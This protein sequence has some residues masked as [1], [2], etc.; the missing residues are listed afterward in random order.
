VPNGRPG[1]R[2][3]V[4]RCWQ[5]IGQLGKKCAALFKVNLRFGFHQIARSSAH[6]MA[7][8]WE[9]RFFRPLTSVQHLPERNPLRI[10]ALVR[11]S[12]NRL[13]RKALRSSSPCRSSSHVS[14]R[15]AGQTTSDAI[16]KPRVV[17]TSA[18]L[19]RGPGLI[20]GGPARPTA[21]C[22]ATIRPNICNLT[23]M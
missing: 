16:E 7:R 21:Y 12:R 3:G 9:C 5:Q 14:S 1:K 17:A 20:A 10:N 22:S 6:R 13:R 4:Q 19:V 18:G 11:K 23:V 2:N 15:R 8:L